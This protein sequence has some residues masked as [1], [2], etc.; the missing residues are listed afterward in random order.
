MTEN[1]AQLP[2]VIIVQV[3]VLCRADRFALLVA[4]AQVVQPTLPPAMA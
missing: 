4:I 2:R 3:A 1:H